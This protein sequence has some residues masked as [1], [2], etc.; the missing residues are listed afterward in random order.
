MLE[1]STSNTMRKR[2]IRTVSLGFIDF[3]FYNMPLAKCSKGYHRT[4]FTQLP[5]A[6]KSVLKLFLL[7]I[8]LMQF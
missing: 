8:Y 6:V 2:K 1:E 5:T 7:L 4:R 3:L